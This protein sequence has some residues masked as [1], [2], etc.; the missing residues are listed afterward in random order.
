MFEGDGKAVVEGEGARTARRLLSLDMLRAVAMLLVVFSH[1][2]DPPR[3]MPELI[4]K[5]IVLLDHIG[6]I[7]VD[8]FFVLSGFLVSGLLFREHIRTG[9]FRTGNF[10]TRRAFKIYPALYFLVFVSIIVQSYIVG[11]STPLQNVTGDLLFLQNYIGAMWGHTWSLAVEEHFYLLLPAVL[12][13]LA[14][15][16]TRTENPFELLPKFALFVAVAELSLRIYTHL[17]HPYTHGSHLFPSHLRFDSLLFGVVISYFY[18]YRHSQFLAFFGKW[19]MKLSVVV[20]ALVAPLLIL[21][22]SH[23]LVSTIGVTLV[24]LFAGILLCWAL[25]L[26][27]PKHWAAGKL[28][29]VGVH[30]YSIYLW[31]YPLVFWLMQ[32]MKEAGMSWMVYTATYGVASI[33]LGITM[34]R[35]IEFPVLYLR[36]SWFSESRSQR[37]QPVAAADNA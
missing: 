21:P 29:F 27:S 32:P 36:D 28:G 26:P 20:P 10:Y 1:S 16:S 18:H 17:N 37:K 4:R 22:R 33:T 15:L 30:S 19:R 31:H 24:F 23:P 13:L 11:E 8:L 7:G 34:A 6:W 35:L 12:L 25:T 3:D 5:P 2:F 9:R 14:K